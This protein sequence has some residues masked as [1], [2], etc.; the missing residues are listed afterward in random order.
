MPKACGVCLHPNRESIDTAMVRNRPLRT[1]EGQFGV[2][3]S[4][5]SRHR[6]HIEEAITKAVEATE[7]TKAVSLLDRL[8]SLITDCKS[9]ALKAS[10][11]RQWAS[12]VSAARE[13]RGCIELLAKLSGQ[14]QQGPNVNVGIGFAVETPSQMSLRQMSDEELDRRI[15]FIIQERQRM[16]G[17]L[18]MPTPVLEAQSNITAIQ[19]CQESAQIEPGTERLTESVAVAGAHYHR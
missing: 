1:I 4:A 16:R 10:Q 2:S 3:R 18:P 19:P 15:D 12:A 11:A 6:G 9:I 5:L 8:E 13:I 7:G 14:L 17:E